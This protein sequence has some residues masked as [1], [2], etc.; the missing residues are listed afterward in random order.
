MSNKINFPSIFND[1]IGPVMRGPSSS[2][3]AGALRIGL[4]A[5]YLMGENIKEINITFDP[6]GSLVTTHESQGSD[7]GLFGG[8][9]GM[10]ADD[11]RLVNFKEELM[12]SGIIA[13]ID[14]V[15]F[16]AKH[17]NTY[18]LNLVNENQQ[19]E[20]IA[21]STG[22]G[23]IEVIEIDNSE[24]SIRGDFYELLIFID[25]LS[26]PDQIRELGGDSEI[27]LHKGTKS[28]IKIKST[29]KFSDEQ[30]NIIND[31]P[32]VK[33]VSLLKPV[34][35]VLGQKK[36][37]VP[38][39]TVEEM[40]EYNKDK[41]LELWELAVHY[42]SKR[43][44][45]THEEV[46]E[47]MR[48]I[49]QIMLN[50]INNGLSGTEYHDRILPSQSPNFKIKNDKKELI[51]SEISNQIIMYITA[52]M[53]T[54]SS[55]GVVVAA[56]TAGSCGALPG[57]IFATSHSLNKP[58]D[59]IIKAMLAAG[60]IGVFIAIKSTFA[61]ESAGCMAEC[62]TGSGMAAAGLVHLAGG[63]LNQ[64][65]G[66]CSMALQN[67]LGLVCDPIGNR[68]EAPCLSRNVMA[69]TNALSCANMAL[70][71]YLH[72]IPLDEVLETFD[73]V[74]RSIK[75]ELRCTALGGLSIT[76]TAKEIE[77]GLAKTQFKS[78]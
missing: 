59:E 32:G 38:F 19:H 73:N 57:T 9:L 65:L 31:L 55:M 3:C 78:C 29:N 61:A 43:G 46:F 37:T 12:K 28:F 69:G 56:P 48:S 62:G 30:I 49:N 33:S 68:V 53:E 40:L 15:S 66:A 25:E 45:I 34:L 20:M 27:I 71:N 77:A 5:R 47:K 6:N 51:G 76:K 26:I 7:M 10:E 75:R 50:S 16:N 13:S 58:E 64:A 70:A 44:N 1:V 4:L 21:I 54:K 14:Y 36:L 74:G 67:V 23:I 18:K 35:P 52:I 63:N 2:H 8:L 11:A 22:G 39:A 24:V 60:L 72:L 42:E 17:P 41:N